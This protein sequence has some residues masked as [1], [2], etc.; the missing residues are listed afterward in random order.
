MVT[1]VGIVGAGPAGLVLGQLLHHAG[2]EAIVLEDRS[3]SYVEQHSRRDD[4]RIATADAP[5]TAAEMLIGGPA[6]PE[7]AV[8]SEVVQAADVR[9]DVRA[10]RG[11][12]RV[13]SGDAGRHC[14]SGRYHVRQ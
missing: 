12:G 9:P 4:R 2:V 11:A 1:Q 5:R 7:T 6:F 13:V 8:V 3:R 10:Q 14:H